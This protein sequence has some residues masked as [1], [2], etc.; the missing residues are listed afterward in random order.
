M[1]EKEIRI[2]QQRLKSYSPDMFAVQRILKEVKASFEYLVDNEWQPGRPSSKPEGTRVVFLNGYPFFRSIDRFRIARET[3]FAWQ[4]IT[5]ASTADTVRKEEIIKRLIEPQAFALIAPALGRLD[6]SKMKPYLTLFTPWGVRPEGKFG[7][8][9]ATVLDRL[10]TMRD[11]LRNRGIQT[12]T[13]VMPADVYATEVNRQV[14]RR[15]SK[16]YFER[17]ADEAQTRG[18][19]VES[20]S[21]LRDRNRQVYE[22]RADEL[23]K[24]SLRE[25]L[26]PQVIAEA[27]SAA[28]RRSGYSFPADIEDAAFRYLRE[29]VCEAEIIEALYTPIKFSAVAKQKDN[30]VDRNLPRIYVIPNELQ[31]PWLK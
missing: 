30:F 6:L 12:K 1:N 11:S 23:T 15:R 13:L 27:L 16:E 14:K 7:R 28:R 5:E 22:K 19:T 20:W 18:F 8:A 29:R 2:D 26:P 4:S 10:K 24:R 3:Y 17:V 25:L 9:E 31:F 21:Q